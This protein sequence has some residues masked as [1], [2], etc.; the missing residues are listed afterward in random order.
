MSRL[1]RMILFN[2]VLFISASSA[3]GA[4]ANGVLVIAHGTS[5]HGGGGGHGHLTAHPCEP[6]H[7]SPWEEA[8]LEATARARLGLKTPVE[9][10]FGMW[11]TECYDRAID[12]L[13]SRLAARSQTLGHLFIV[14]LFISDF[15][16]VIEAQKFIFHLRPNSPIPELGLKRSNH[17]GP[18][19]YGRAIGYDSLISEILADRATALLKTA[20]ARGY[21]L[22]NT[23]LVLVMHGPVE[24]DANREWMK[25]G[26]A[27]VDDLKRRLAFR[28]ASAVSLRDD[29]APDVRDRATAELRERVDKASRE[30]GIAIVLPLLLS[31]GGIEQGIA[32]RLKG[33]EAVW[34]GETLFPDPRMEIWLRH[35][36]EAA[37]LDVTGVSGAR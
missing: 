22:Q 27:Y 21:S 13:R 14:P 26:N 35:R 5:L 24:D 2:L 23:D 15:S 6:E 36:L 20:A 11:E 10:A 9:I 16:L 30:G 1:S 4:T 31:R 7:P 19:T 34:S 12:R 33:H 28:H 18:L 32:H 25:M 3:L 8:V 29:A 37:E 17:T